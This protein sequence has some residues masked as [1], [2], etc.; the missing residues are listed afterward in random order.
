MYRQIFI[1]N[2]VDSYIDR[3]IFIDNNLDSYKHIY[4]VWELRIDCYISLSV[5]AHLS[6][7]SWRITIHTDSQIYYY[8]S[9]VTIDIFIEKNLD[10]YIDRHIFIDNNVDIYID[11]H[12][13]ID[14]NVDTV[15]I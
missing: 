13:F 12:I 6:C 14:N 8:F 11:R 9:S 10:S 15:V 7:Y 5:L 2:N 3:H 4:I 1:D